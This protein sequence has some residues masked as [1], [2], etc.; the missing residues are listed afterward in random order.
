MQNEIY[1]DNDQEGM[2]KN[3]RRRKKQLYESIRERMEFYF[4]DANLQKDR[5]LS[6]LLKNDPRK[7]KI[8]NALPYLQV[9]SLNGWLLNRIFNFRC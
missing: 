1:F 4:S 8:N 6:Q 7:C 5:F 3:I 9:S 2:P